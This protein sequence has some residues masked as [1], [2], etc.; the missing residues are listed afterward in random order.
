MERALYG[1]CLAHLLHVVRSLRSA[2]GRAMPQ[3]QGWNGA[4]RSTRFRQLLHS[5][6][7]FQ[8]MGKIVVTR[9]RRASFIGACC[10]IGEKGP[11]NRNDLADA[12]N[13]FSSEND[14]YKK[15]VRV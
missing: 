15:T 5:Q 2:R 10:T 4:R 7:P 1:V 13:P 9:Q 14:G 3:V 12:S 11:P 8:A 6:S